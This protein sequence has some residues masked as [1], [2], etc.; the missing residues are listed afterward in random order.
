MQ[1]RNIKRETELRVDTSNS[2]PYE[3]AIDNAA[4]S[5]ITNQEINEERPKATTRKQLPPEFYQYFLSD[6]AKEKKP[7]PSESSLIAVP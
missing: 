5:G 7:S 4:A 6:A 1:T 3:M 2:F